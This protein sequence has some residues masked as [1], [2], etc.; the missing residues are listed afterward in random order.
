MIEK[1][2]ERLETLYS[3]NEKT[4]KNAYEEQDWEKFDLFMHRNEGVYFATKI[5]H[6]VAKEYGN[7]W[8]PCSEKM[9]ELKQEV[10][11][12]ANDNAVYQGVM[13][14]GGFMV[15]EDGWI[16]T[17]HVLAW[18]PLPAPYQKGE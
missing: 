10:L 18:Q 5:V 17:K 2:L 15:F 13:A 9:P 12:T 7:G 16:D 11:I 6:E 3:M 8:I 14:N 4:K 1:I